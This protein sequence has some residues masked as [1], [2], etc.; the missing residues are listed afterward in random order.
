MKGDDCVPT[1]QQSRYDKATKRRSK[2]AC[3]LFGVHVRSINRTQRR[4]QNARESHAHFDEER[5]EFIGKPTIQS[6]D[7]VSVEVGRIF[8]KAASR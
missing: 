8:V 4:I 2:Y 3:S 5:G 1:P 7:E 6:L